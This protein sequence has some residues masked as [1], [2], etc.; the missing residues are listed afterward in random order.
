MSRKT[1]TIIGGCCAFILL[2]ITGIVLLAVFGIR[3]AV[4]GYQDIQGKADAQALSFLTAIGKGED[5]SAYALLSPNAK[6]QESETIFHQRMN[7]FRANTGDF[8]PP[9]QAN[10][11]N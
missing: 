1:G 11:V 3:K 5:S 10:G 9:F 6:R 8:G 7:E 2:V 4:T